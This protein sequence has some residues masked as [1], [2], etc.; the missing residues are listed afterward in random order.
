MQYK[1]L[2]L[3]VVFMACMTVSNAHAHSEGQISEKQRQCIGKAA[4]KS[5]DRKKDSIIQQAEFR[6]WR[7]KRLKELKT[8]QL[9]DDLGLLFVR[10]MSSCFEGSKKEA[11]RILDDVDQ[12]GIM[13]RRAKI[14]WT[15]KG[16]QSAYEKATQRLFRRL[17][18]NDDKQ[19][20]NKEM[21]KFYRQLHR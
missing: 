2:S 16:T 7:S 20:S 19:L 13:R 4:T 21:A 15:A 9:G 14:N 11:S 8:Q 10:N 17:D 5:I 1:D 18:A 12:Y 3:A 6:T